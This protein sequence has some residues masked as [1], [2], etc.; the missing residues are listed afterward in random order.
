MITTYAYCR[1]VAEA[2]RSFNISRHEPARIELTDD[3]VGLH[4]IIETERLNQWL[5]E[6]GGARTTADALA[7][8]YLPDD[9]R[10]A[11]LADL[12]RHI[13]FDY[14]ATRRIEAIHQKHKIAQTFKELFLN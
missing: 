4:I 3:F 5:C 13:E 10:M 11:R 9:P 8:V 1:H 7:G 14:T 6:A 2:D 12:V